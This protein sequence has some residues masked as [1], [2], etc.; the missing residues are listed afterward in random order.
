MGGLDE[1]PILARSSGSTVVD[2][3]G[4]QYLDFQSGQ[5]CGA[6][7]HQDPRMVA[8]IERTMR[9]LM[10]ATNTMLNVPRLRLRPLQK[11]LFLVSGSDSIEAAIDLA[12]KATGG[13]D[14][15]G[16]HAGLHGSTSF[17]S[18]SVTFNWTQYEAG[19][20]LEGSTAADS[21]HFTGREMEVLALLAEG[22]SNKAIA[23]KLDISVHTAKFHVASIL[24]K[25]DAT[26]RTDAV[27]HAVRL[28]LLML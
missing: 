18:R 28:G 9:S 17:V 26:G 3:D 15:L 22:A 23:K 2:T 7:G 4:K 20:N 27:S 13:V 11:S 5:M 8:A 10:H 16:L 14:I 21:I 12:R 6:L 25:L 24:E 1:R 19:E